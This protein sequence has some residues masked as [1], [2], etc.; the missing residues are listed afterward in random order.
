MLGEIPKN[1]EIWGSLIIIFGLAVVLSQN[2]IEGPLK[3]QT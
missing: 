1:Q 2:D 3:I